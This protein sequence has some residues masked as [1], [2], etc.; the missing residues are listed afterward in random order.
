MPLVGAGVDSAAPYTLTSLAITPL[1]GSDNQ[2][3]DWPGN[4]DGAVS[5]R[6]G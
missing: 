2:V 5:I 6:I 3:H 4:H 1:E